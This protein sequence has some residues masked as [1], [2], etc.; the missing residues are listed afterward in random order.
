MCDTLYINGLPLPAALVRAIE[1]G[2]WQTPKNRDVWRSLFPEE[3]IVQPKLYPLEP[4]I[5]LFP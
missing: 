2:I 1:S 5:D 4:V 3:E